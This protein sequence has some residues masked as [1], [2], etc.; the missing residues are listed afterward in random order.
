MVPK[1]SLNLYYIYVFTFLLQAANQTIY[2]EMENY[3]PKVNISV[4]G[5]AVQYHV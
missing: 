1:K 3:Y 4:L 2:M 5:K